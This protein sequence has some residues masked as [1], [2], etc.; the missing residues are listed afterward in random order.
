[1][2]NLLPALD[3]FAILHSPEGC[4][5]WGIDRILSLKAPATR[6]GQVVSVLKLFDGT[7][8]IQQIASLVGIPERA[9]LDIY[10]KLNE[11]GVIYKGNDVQYQ[12]LLQLEVPQHI[13]LSSIVVV[14][15]G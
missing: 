11:L 14:G 9:V 15:T 3:S 10:N 8:S 2:S 12:Q 13:C 5:L 4:L 1:M 6:V 7:H